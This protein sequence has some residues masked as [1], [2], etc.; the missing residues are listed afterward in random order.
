MEFS[1]ARAELGLAPVPSLLSQHYDLEF[2]LFPEHAS[3][4]YDI[5]RPIGS[6]ELTDRLRGILSIG[7]SREQLEP[8]SSHSLKA[9]ILAYMNIWGCDFCTSELL[10]YHVN[11]EHGSALNYTRDCL[12]KPIREMVDMMLA[13]HEGWFKPAAGRDEF[14][15]SKES[16][17]PLHEQFEVDTGYGL[18]EAVQALR[19]ASANNDDLLD[20]KED[21][22]LERLRAE[23]SISRCGLVEYVAD[24]EQLAFQSIEARRE[25]LDEISEPDSSSTSSSVEEEVHGGMAE[26]SRH[27]KGTK[28][29]MP[30]E[31]CDLMTLFRHS[32]TKMVHYG[33]VLRSDKTG[34]GRLLSQAYYVVTGEADAFF[35]KCKHCF[36]H[37]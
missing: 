10:G 11:K 6:V 21:D 15:S 24:E 8:I 23:G 16:C 27:L 14:F 9:T 36:G 29:M 7:F 30:G 2:I 31:N 13:V 4:A 22:R 17:S 3:L 35:P 34:F 33:N 1:L 26:I 20:P 12:S 32:R 19:K 25:E 18:E 37:I 28:R 5:Q